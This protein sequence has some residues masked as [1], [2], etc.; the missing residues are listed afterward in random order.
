MVVTVDRVLRR[1]NQ[2]GTCWTGT[3]G[4]RLHDR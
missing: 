2:F 1:S 4:S 3:I